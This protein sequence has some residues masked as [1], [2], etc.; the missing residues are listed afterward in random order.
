MG[1]FLLDG[2]KFG[3]D[4]FHFQA[5]PFVIGCGIGILILDIV[6]CHLI[7]QKRLKHKLNV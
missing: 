1:F 6:Y 4:T 5:F 3:F 7:Y 2:G